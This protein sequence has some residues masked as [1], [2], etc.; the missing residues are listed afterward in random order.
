MLFTAKPPLAAALAL[1]LI[2]V[3]AACA[4]AYTSLSIERGGSIRQASSGKITFQA[5]LV[6][7]SCNLTLRGE[8]STGPFREELPIPA[9][10]VTSVEW[11]ECTGGEIIEILGLP[12]QSR[13]ERLLEAANEPRIAGI[14]PEALTGGLVTLRESGARAVGWELL[15]GGLKCLFGG[16]GEAP[17]ALLPLTRTS[18]REGRYFYSLGTLTL[19]EEVRFLKSAGSE[20]CPPS[21]VIRGRLNAAEPAQ[22]AIFQ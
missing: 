9:G 16:R 2:A 21:G 11:N 20:L 13:I 1:A 3:M 8:L 19:L 6:S 5:G 7:V 4:S 17:S 12:W 22:T 10:R 14:R 18:T 15:I